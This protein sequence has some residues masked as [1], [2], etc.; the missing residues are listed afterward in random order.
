MAQYD[1]PYGE[2]ITA[3]ARV[4]LTQMEIVKEL[5]PMVL[6]DC[7]TVEAFDAKRKRIDDYIL[8]GICRGEK[9]KQWYYSKIPNGQA[10]PDTAKEKRNIKNRVQRIYGKLKKAIYTASDEKP[11]DDGVIEIENMYEAEGIAS[12]PSANP[13]FGEHLLR[14]PLRMVIVAPSGMVCVYYFLFCLPINYF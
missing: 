12:T 6:N 1:L 3:F 4:T 5:R 14:I 11:S 9:H 13:Y 2:L 10:T 8:D 7:K